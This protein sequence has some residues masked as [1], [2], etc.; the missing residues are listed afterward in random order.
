M[1]YPTVT[2]IIVSAVVAL[3]ITVSVSFRQRKYRMNMKRSIML[4]R[5]CEDLQEKDEGQRYEYG[6]MVA[7]EPEHIY[8]SDILYEADD[9]GLFA[10][11]KMGKMQDYPNTRV[12]VRITDREEE[13]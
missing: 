12:R 8:Y 2:E 9:L 5:L 6:L 3:I 11:M 1:I 4:L 7:G 13:E 10:F